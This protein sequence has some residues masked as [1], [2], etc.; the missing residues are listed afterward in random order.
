MDTPLEQTW[1]FSKP[2]LKLKKWKY[3]LQLRRQTLL[4]KEFQNL[5]R[6]P[7]N[8]ETTRSVAQTLGQ[9]SQ[10]LARNRTTMNLTMKWTLTRTLQH[11]QLLPRT[12]T[13]TVQHHLHR[14][15]PDQQDV[16]RL[17]SRSQHKRPRNLSPLTKTQPSI[18]ETPPKMKEKHR[19]MTMMLLASVQT[20]PMKASILAQQR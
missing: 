13:W 7:L 11:R 17:P 1:S 3:G 12:R 10:G 8:D 9:T 15:P 2:S 16:G 5:N 18:L 19:T 14:L 6:L 20:I 4:G